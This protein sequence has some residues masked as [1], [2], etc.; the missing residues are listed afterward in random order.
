MKMKKK[1]L[2]TGGAGFIGSHLSERLSKNAQVIVFD[3]LYQGNKLNLNRNIKL[4][5]SDVR[6]RKMLEKYSKNCNAI[7]HLAAIIGVDIVAKNKVENMNV[8]FDGLRNICEIAKKNKVK[9]II[10]ASSS[11]VYGKLNYE[12]K[13]KE[14]AIIAP[15]SGYAM[16]KRS[17]EIYL[18]NF[19]KENNIHCAS[20]RL[21]NVYGKR[22]DTRMV[23][24]RFV[25]LAKKNKNIEIYGDGK[26][27]RDFTHI[28][29]CIKTFV[30]LEK[31]LKDMKFSIHLKGVR[32][33]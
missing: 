27:T 24:P 4:V 14:N 25:E 33:K 30:R 17:G 15:N 5:K 32:L 9:K 19:S 8:E 16:A 18:K 11:G 22:Q 29:D 12:N 7:F 1:F 2:I 23:I 20:I 13:V 28:N 3:N 31:K 10:Y 26:Q 21:F 6:N